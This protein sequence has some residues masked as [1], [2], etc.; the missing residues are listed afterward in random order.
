M[1]MAHLYVE[2]FCAKLHTIVIYSFLS[3]RDNSIDQ[4]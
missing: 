2:I 1:R 4:S 3:E